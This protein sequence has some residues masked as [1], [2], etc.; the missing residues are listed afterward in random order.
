MFLW[1]SCCEAISRTALCPGLALS[2]LSTTSCVAGRITFPVDAGFMATSACLLR[3]T[4]VAAARPLLR[5]GRGREIEARGRLAGRQVVP[6]AQNR[7][8]EHSLILHHCKRYFITAGI[9]LSQKVL[10]SEGS[11]GSTVIL[12]FEGVGVEGVKLIK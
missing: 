12:V 6:T 3:A 2:A 9:L 7:V 5:C 8:Q 10:Y 11:R 4:T 1:P